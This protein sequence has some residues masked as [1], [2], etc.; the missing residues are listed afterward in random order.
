VPADFEAIAAITLEYERNLA[1]LRG[2]PSE[3][4]TIIAGLTREEQIKI[5]RTTMW[6]AVDGPAL[7]APLALLVFDYAVLDGFI[8]AREVLHDALGIDDKQNPFT[9]LVSHVAQGALPAV[10]RRFQALALVRLVKTELWKAAPI[11]CADRL[12]GTLAIAS[13]WIRG[14]AV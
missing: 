11:H 9:L 7:P 2:Q 4:V 13:E 1:P 3:H 12:C 5:L 6:F 10:C 8:S 14:E